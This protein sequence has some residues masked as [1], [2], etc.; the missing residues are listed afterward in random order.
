MTTGH[1]CHRKTPM[2]TGEPIRGA[3][4]TETLLHINYVKEMQ[5]NKSRVQI[6]I[7][8]S[9]ILNRCKRCSI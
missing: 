3:Y 2:H 5:Y 1:L 4:S 6:S 9:G 7:Q 8:T